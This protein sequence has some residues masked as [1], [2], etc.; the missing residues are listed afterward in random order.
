M[1]YTECKIFTSV[2]PQNSFTLKEFETTTR[3]IGLIILQTLQ[4]VC[5]CSNCMRNQLLYC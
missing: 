4:T 1:S 5:T 2:S 3:K